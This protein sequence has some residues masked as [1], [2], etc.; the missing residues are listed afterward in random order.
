[1][2][3]HKQILLVAVAMSAWIGCSGEP[4]GGGSSGTSSSSSSSGSTGGMG[5]AGG[6]GGAGAMGGAGGVVEAGGMGGVGGIGGM[7]GAGGVGGTGGTGGTGGAG[8]SGVDPNSIKLVSAGGLFGCVLFADGRF[9]CW[10][11]NSYGELGLGDSN[12]RGDGPGEMGDNLPAVSIGTGRTVVGLASGEVHNVVLLD[13]GHLKVW[14]SA[15][16]NSYG[17]SVTRGDNPGEMGDNLPEVDLGTGLVAKAIGAGEYHTCAISTE[18]KI[19]CW[20]N[21]N[22]GKLGQGTI[23]GIGVNPGELGEALP[24][25]DLGTN[26]SI[27]LFTA[28]YDHNCVVFAGGSMKCWGRSVFGELGLGDT[29]NRGDGPNEMG[30]NLP[31]VNLGTGKT[32]VAI[33][34]GYNHT[35]A[36]LNDGSLKCWGSNASGQ[37]GLGDT[38]NRG[39]QPNEMGD[40]LPAVDLGT[41]KV[42][43]AVSA[44]QLHT[45][46]VLNDGTVKCWGSNKYG[47]LGLGDTQNRGDGPNEMGDNLPAI[48]LGAG[49]VA[50]AITSGANL[51]C[52]VLEGKSLKCWGHNQYGALG[53]GDTVNRGDNPGEMGD[54]LPLT[55]P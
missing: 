52:A 26:E 29:N 18:D 55:V 36:I 42:A 31:T 19:K 11:N 50:T 12:H 47:N 35:C 39:D 30:V 2:Q 23:L 27:V 4:H 13:N 53:L 17:D 21:N 45:C 7:G 10:G 9:K 34:A 51:N 1:M 33:S 28:G 38:N 16:A 44:G 54:N 5:A 8:G 3:N 37:L 40:N 15:S 46:A 22:Y 32:P 14:G 24:A 48:D 43:I 25:I 6:T 49:A 20:G 41:G